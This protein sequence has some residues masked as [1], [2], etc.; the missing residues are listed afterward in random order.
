MPMPEDVRITLGLAV[1]AALLLGIWWVWWRLPKREVAR[2]ALKIRDP[3][4]RA[5]VEDNFRKT[6]GQALGG[7]AVLFGAVIAAVVTYLQFSKQQQS[8]HDLLISNQVSKGFEQLGSE[9]IVVR[10][11]GTYALEGVMNGSDQYHQPVLEA[12]SAFVRE[13]AK[14][15]ATLATPGPATQGP[16]PTDIQAAL[17][18]IGRRSVGLG[19]VNLDN[20]SI[21]GANPIGANLNGADLIKA[22]LTGANVTSADLTGANRIGATLDHATLTSA[23]LIGAV[24]TG[25]NLAGAVLTGANLAGAKLVHARLAGAFLAGAVLTGANME[26]ADLPEAHLAGA[27][28]IGANLAYANLSRADLAHAELAH[29]SLVRANL[30]HADLPDANLT[31]ASLGHTVLNGANLTGANLN[32]AMLNGASL[33]GQKQRVDQK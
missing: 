15:P 27:N 24:L 18:V 14:L 11:G 20:M 17:T 9:K 12:L 4:A 16:P 26:S 25:A 19:I 7:A 21:V 31:G 3:K 32:A 2:L 13:G 22:D 5:D 6:V 23:N 28:L 1:I 10:L 30:D 8:S 29:V 33:D